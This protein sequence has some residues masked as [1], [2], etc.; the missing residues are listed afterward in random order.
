MNARL[1]FAIASHVQADVLVIDEVLSG[2]DFS[3]QTKCLRRI[4]TAIR[5]GVAVLF[6]SHNMRSVLSMCTSALLLDRGRVVESG[7]P[8]DVVKAYYSTGGVWKPETLSDPA[9]R[10]TSVKVHRGRDVRQRAPS[11][12]GVNRPRGARR[13]KGMRHLARSVR[14]LGRP[15]RCRH[16]LP[17]LSRGAVAPR[18]GRSDS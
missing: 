8:S 15:L 6:M 18:G 1:G 10:V 9:V 2:G 16:E 14:D 17:T 7:T 12:G 5:E 3:F 4:E 13:E 11:R